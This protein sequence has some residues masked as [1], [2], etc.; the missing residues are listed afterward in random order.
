MISLPSVT[1]ACIDCIDTR[2]AESAIE[3]CKN[4]IDFGEI[5]LLTSLETSSPHVIK[6][7]PV[8]NWFE[9]SAFILFRLN[10]FITTD[11]VLICQYD[12]YILNPSLWDNDFLKYDYIGA[13]VK[14][15]DIHRV[16]NGGFS[17]RSKKLL[18][19]LAKYPKIYPLIIEDYSIC[20][21][22]RA[23]LEHN[24][25]VFAPMDIAKKFSCDVGFKDCPE[26]HDIY[27]TFGFH[28]IS[29]L[30]KLIGLLTSQAKSIKND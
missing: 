11:H 4:G 28:G 27:N 30:N 23:E 3:N 20:V 17:L 1:L 13:P 29:T 10:E 9:Y 16:G 2:R 15:H 19:Y 21:E 25:F 6:I 18:E 26:E 24:G 8:L 12:G 7:D 22:R 5:K 14:W